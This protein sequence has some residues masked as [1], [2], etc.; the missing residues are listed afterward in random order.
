[1][2]KEVAPLMRYDGLLGSHLNM[3]H[4]IDVIVGGVIVMVHV[5]TIKNQG[6]GR[7]V[8]RACAR[9]QSGSDI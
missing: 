4:V 9:A 8:P 5:E 1:M 2:R 3:Q 7:V 6:V